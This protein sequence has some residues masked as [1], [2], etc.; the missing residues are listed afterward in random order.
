LDA[1]TLVLGI[2][3]VPL[4]LLGFGCLLFPRLLLA[5]MDSHQLPLNT[6][7]DEMFGTDIN[8]RTYRWQ[9]PLFRWVFG[10]GLLF[11]GVAFEA[12]ALF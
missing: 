6:A 2:V 11:L 12:N 1:E 10:F 4:L 8:R 9:R 5:Y 7:L 3:G